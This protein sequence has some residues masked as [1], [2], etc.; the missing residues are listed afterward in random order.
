MLK[1]GVYQALV[2]AM[3]GLSGVG[4]PGA[5]HA[6]NEAVPGL[7]AMQ[8]ACTDSG[9]R[10]E[11]SWAYDD[12]GVQWGRVVSCSTE[13]G[14]ITCQDNICRGNRGVLTDGGRDRSDGAMWFPAEP[15]AFSAALSELSG[16]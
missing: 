1:V 11:L 5:V 4:V 14:H 6:G 16:E 13:S 10:F 8:K 12:Q 3:I 7:A 2:A 15:L 9:G